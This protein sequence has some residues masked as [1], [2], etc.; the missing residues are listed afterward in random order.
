MKEGGAREEGPGTGGDW[1][2][3]GHSI[4]AAHGGANGGMS[5]VG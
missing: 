2:D 3:P 1:R 5:H 4:T